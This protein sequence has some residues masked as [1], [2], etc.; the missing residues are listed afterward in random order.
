M[1]FNIVQRVTAQS[2]AAPTT[3]TVPFASTQVGTLLLIVI[4]T[5]G[6]S[7]NAAPSTPAGWTAL[8]SKLSS[9]NAVGFGLFAFNKNPGGI[10]NVVVTLNGTTPQGS[11]AVGYEVSGVTEA[12]A[13]N[14]PDT[15]ATGTAIQSSAVQPLTSGEL[16][17]AACVTAGVTT[18]TDSSPSSWFNKNLNQQ[19]TGGTTNATLDVW[20][21]PTAYYGNTVIAGTLNASTPF[22]AMICQLATDMGAGQFARGPGGVTAF[23]GYSGALGVQ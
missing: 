5:V 13:V 3:L 12:F 16:C 22:Y 23:P 17:I 18:L 9:N 7:P 4:G 10:T 2:S 15:A 19:S 14:K 21:G 1:A 11:C 20:F 6:G 8:I